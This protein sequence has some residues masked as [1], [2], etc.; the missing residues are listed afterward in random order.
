MEKLAWLSPRKLATQ[1]EK[2]GAEP[3][4]FSPLSLL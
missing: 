1:F 3:C 2:V 4:V